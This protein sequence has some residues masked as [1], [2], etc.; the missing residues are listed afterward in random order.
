MNGL[1]HAAHWFLERGWTPL[2][3][4]PRGKQPL[5]PWRRLQRE[6]PTAA[7]LEQWWSLCPEANVGVV[8]GHLSGLAVLDLDGPMA[9]DH[10]MGLGFPEDA[11]QARTRNGL[12]VYCHI[13]GPIRT[14]ILVPGVEV[15]GEGAYVVAPPSIHPSGVP[16]TWVTPPDRK[17]PPLP[18]WAVK[19]VERKEPDRPGWVVHAL[20]GVEEGRRN[21]TCARLAG[22]LVAKGVSAEEAEWWLLGWNRFNRPPLAEAEVRATVASTF[23]RGRRQRTEA[24]PYAEN[25]L[26]EFLTG[27]GRECTH[28]ERS[29]YQAVCTLEWKRGLAPG[30][31]LCVSCRELH[32]CGGVSPQRTGHV[33]ARLAARGLIEYAPGRRGLN[34]KA[35]TVRRVVPLPPLPEDCAQR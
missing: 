3:I 13:N 29:T 15:R 11:P 14:K 35:A 26:L 7:D 25:S 32:A 20:R 9:I 30:V 4:H 22:H 2:P 5:F 10:A 17:S 6:R 27:W 34:G 12:H 33:L 24:L 19:S 16:Y 23:T 31:T 8:T 28:G 21:S 18:G 1:L